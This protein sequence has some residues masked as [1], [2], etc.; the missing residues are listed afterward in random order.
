MRIRRVQEGAA[1]VEAAG[2]SS[3]APKS[4]MACTRC[5]ASASAVDEPHFAEQGFPATYVAMPVSLLLFT[6]V[7]S[8]ACSSRCPG[9]LSKADTPEQP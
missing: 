3:S 7:V 2:D 9:V 6:G 1:F 4:S 8:W 5:C